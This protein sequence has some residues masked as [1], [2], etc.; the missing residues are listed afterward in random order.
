MIEPTIYKLLAGDSA[1]TDLVGT[2]IYP[3]VREQSDGLPAITY[4]TISN[5][6]GS[7]ISGLNGLVEGRIQINCFASTI[8]GAA[9]LAEIVK[10]SIGTH[11]A[12]VI[13]CVLLEE[14]NDLPSIEPE[15]EQMNVFAKTM[16]F[17][18]LYKEN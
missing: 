15:N 17:Y 1:I 4:Q 2:K 13:E 5:I 18:I 10:G 6:Y 14:M 8:L 3:L 12:G 16:D 7:D 9:Q 11:R